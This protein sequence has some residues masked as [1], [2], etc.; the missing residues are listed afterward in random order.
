MKRYAN[1][2]INSMWE[3]KLMFAVY[4]DE[5]K[6]SVTFDL[7]FILWIRNYNN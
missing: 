5:I 4:E 1:T 2:D 3:G 6:M 7:I